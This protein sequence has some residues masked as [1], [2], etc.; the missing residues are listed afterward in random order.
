[1]EENRYTQDFF[2]FAFLFSLNEYVG[3]FQ[4]TKIFIVESN[5]DTNS[6]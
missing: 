3:N 6:A 4:L 1:M 5:Y 2:L